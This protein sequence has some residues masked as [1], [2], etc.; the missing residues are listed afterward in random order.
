VNILNGYHRTRFDYDSRREVLWRCLYDFYLKRWIGES[1]CVLELGAGYGHFI[2]S[3][4]V[5]RRIAVDIWAEMPRHIEPTVEGHVGNVTDLSFVEE[6]SVDFATA[7]NVSAL[8]G[9]LILDK[10]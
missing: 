9:A 5:R 3:I 4:K 10:T 8:R 6:S 7:S 2:N 1:G